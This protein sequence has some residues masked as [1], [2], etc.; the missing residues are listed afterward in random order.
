[1]QNPLSQWADKPIATPDELLSPSK[2]HRYDLFQPTKVMMMVAQSIA[3][4]ARPYPT[5]RSGCDIGEEHTTATN[6]AAVM[7]NSAR[8]VQSSPLILEAVAVIE[9]QK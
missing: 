6:G 1:L 4:L 2:T 5:A 9:F 3:R 8:P 7:A